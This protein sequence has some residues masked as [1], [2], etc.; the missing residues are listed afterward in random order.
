MKQQT[1]SEW[2]YQGAFVI[3]FR[4][5]TDPDSGRYFG[6]VEHVASYEAAHFESLDDFLGFITQV[7]ARVRA[8]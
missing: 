2:K 5:E 7:L 3:Q 4:P 6:R 1:D 8:D